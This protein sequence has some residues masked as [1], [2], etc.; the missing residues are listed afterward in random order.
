M[1]SCPCKTPG[2]TTS[3]HG[4]T[5]ATR[6]PS[7]GVPSG[8]WTTTPREHLFRS[9]RL[10]VLEDDT[11]AQLLSELGIGHAYDLDVLH[12]RVTVQEVFDL[13]VQPQ[14]TL[15]THASDQS[16]ELQVMSQ[17][18]ATTVRRFTTR[19]HPS[20]ALPGS[21]VADTDRGY[22]FSPPR[23]TMSFSRPTMRQ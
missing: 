5:I 8:C 13:T 22:T 2:S 21:Q 16:L 11:R 7:I 9:R 4:S 6:R 17:G 1:R 23:M 18:S 10:A 12:S 3:Q 14:H 20:F 15:E 19:S